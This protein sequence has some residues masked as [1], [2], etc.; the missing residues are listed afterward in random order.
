MGYAD[1]GEPVGLLLL[2]RDPADIPWISTEFFTARYPRQA[3]TG[4]LYYLA[5]T[6]THPDY[7]RGGMLIE[8]L[9]AAGDKAAERGAVVGFDMCAFNV[10][11][12]PI[13]D[14]AKAT[15]GDRGYTF[16]LVDR[17]EFWVAKHADSGVA[18]VPTPYGPIQDA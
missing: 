1:T 10:D 8:L 12:I 9:R 13:P 18:D 2:A 3:A 14:I 17:Q 15:L 7:Q 4:S 16:E 6:V 5:F 11:T